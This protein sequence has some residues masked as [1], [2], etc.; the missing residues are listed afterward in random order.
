MRRSTRSNGS[1]A[2]AASRIAAWA[3]LA[4]SPPLAAAADT[5]P[6]GGVV[7]D[8]WYVSAE[9]AAGWVVASDQAF[10]GT[11]SLK[12]QPVG[13][14]QFAGIEVSGSFAAGTLSF[15]RS[16]SSEEGYDFLR[17]YIDGVVQQEWTGNAGWAV[18]AFGVSAGTHT[19]RWE[20]SK[21]DAVAAGA[22]AAWIDAVVLP[23]RS[24]TPTFALGA[25]SHAIGEATNS[26]VISVHRTGS[27]SGT[28]SVRYATVDGT[29]VAGAD[30]VATSGTLSFGS[31]VTTRTFAVS[32]VD[33]GITEVRETFSVT[34]TNPN[35][36]AVVASPATASVA[37]ADDDDVFPAGGV[38]PA[39]WVE[40]PGAAAGWSVAS[41]VAQEG[42]Q[43]L[44]SDSIG[45]RQIA[46]I[47]VS[48]TFAA[49]A[50]SFAR[51]VSSEADF[52][53]LRFYVDGVLR[54]QWSGEAEWAVS[55]FDVAAGRRTFRWEYAK[56]ESFATGADAAWIDAVVLPPQG[57]APRLAGATSRKVHGAAGTFDL[58]LASTT[59]SP[60]T[61]PRT[62]PAHTIVFTFDKP[63]V[64]GTATVTEGAA[65]VATPSFGGNE[66]R[67]PLTG[68]ADVQYVT[69][70]VG[71]VVAADGG[72]GG[73]GSVR[74]GF[75]VGDAT[76]NGTVTVSDLA[77]VNAQIAQP[78]TAS[79]YLRDVNVSGTLTVADKGIANARI[80]KALPAP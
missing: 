74:I 68:V 32:I 28:A 60:T 80:T 52:D 29:A 49:G 15:A 18:A 14:G 25:A 73:S 47:E 64:A 12:S 20:Y 33:D 59:A 46:A 78:V 45:D 40:P 6:A 63:V 70:T 51:K 11:L 44:R 36:G 42:S 41:D 66:M 24:T 56:D 50:V 72:S 38:V 37:I 13:N 58:P 67:V 35:A 22:D 34:L 65:S 55:S 30:Y 3:V 7:P 79:N 27:T 39:G 21:D 77:Q 19:F 71:N 9:A 8:G 48:G 10:E 23:A 54:E 76:Q 1:F 69:V 62:G 31:G 75:L 16:V 5:F 4:V 43:S 57:E 61:E 53:F 26:L 17:F 2:A